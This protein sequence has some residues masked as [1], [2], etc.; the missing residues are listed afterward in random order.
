[1]AEVLTSSAIIACPHGGVASASSL[2]AT[3]AFRV[4]G[5]AVLNASAI[6]S[7]PFACPEPT[8]CTEVTAWILAAPLIFLGE[9]QALSTRSTPVTNGGPGRIEIAGQAV[10]RLGG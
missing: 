3:S 6:G 7:C 9:L 1:M 2:P 4:A 8:P 10:L 5:L